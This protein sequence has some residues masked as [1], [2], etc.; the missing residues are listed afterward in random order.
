MGSRLAEC[1]YGIDGVVVHR[2][3]EDNI[4]G[5]GEWYPPDGWHKFVLYKHAGIPFAKL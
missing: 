1:V 5:S 4:Y 3:E 2:I